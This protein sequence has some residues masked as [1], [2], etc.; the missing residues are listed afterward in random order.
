MSLLVNYYKNK[1]NLCTDDE[2]LLALAN[3]N[4]ID[5]IKYEVLS[6]NEISQEI[7]EKC[8]Y[9]ITKNVTGDNLSIDLVSAIINN[10]NCP[11]HILEAA[12]N[13]A[14]NSTELNIISNLIIYRRENISR[15]YVWIVT[16]WP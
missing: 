11:L 9:Y 13:L 4:D 15:V 3:M 14:K 16:N 8:Y 12:Y 10:P 7:L 1:Y 5:D 6:K 2:I